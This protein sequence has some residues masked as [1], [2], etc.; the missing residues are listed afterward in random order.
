LIASRFLGTAEF[1]ELFY[2]GA[3]DRSESKSSFEV[4]VTGEWLLKGD[5]NPFSG[6]PTTAIVVEPIDIKYG[7]TIGKANDW[8]SLGPIMLVDILYLT[9]DLQITRG[10]ANTESI[11]VW[12]RLS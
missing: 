5:R 1:K 4:T 2:S 11:F 7:S 8:A 9:N 12:R 10:N 3:A 6:A